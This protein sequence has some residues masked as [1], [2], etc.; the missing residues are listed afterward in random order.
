MFVTRCV[1][2]NHEELTVN[3]EC[4]C[5]CHTPAPQPPPVCCDPSAPI[6]KCCVCG[7]DV[8]TC[9]RT[10]PVDNDYRCPLHGNGVELNAGEWVCSDACG[11]ERMLAGYVA[12]I[13]AL[14]ASNGN[15]FVA[16]AKWWEWQKSN[17]TMWQ[18]DQQSAFEEAKRR[19]FVF[20]PILETF[21]D[22][23]IAALEAQLAEA[24]ETINAMRDELSRRE[25]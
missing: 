4:S 8:H 16:G 12:R 21:F 6:V 14:E 17:A 15:A 10:E 11:Y 3:P 2:C 24:Q 13:A 9:E 20:K 7:A 22:E 5:G 23:K 19:G 25:S 1:E 18:S